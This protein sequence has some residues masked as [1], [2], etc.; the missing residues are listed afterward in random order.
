[1]GEIRV[2]VVYHGHHHQLLPFGSS[3]W[4]KEVVA[5]LKCIIN[6]VYCTVDYFVSFLI[7]LSACE[8]LCSSSR[9]IVELLQ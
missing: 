4:E 9:P 2:F 6:D 7:H 1:M 3:W 5:A 8:I